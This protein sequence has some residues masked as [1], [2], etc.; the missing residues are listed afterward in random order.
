MSVASQRNNMHND[1][2]DKKTQKRHTLKRYNG[3]KKLNKWVKS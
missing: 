2:K 1:Y 3:H